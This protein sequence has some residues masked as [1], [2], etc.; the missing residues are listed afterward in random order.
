M[1]EGS[2]IRITDEQRAIR[3]ALRND[4]GR[5]MSARVA[6]AMIDLRATGM[7]VADVCRTTSGVLRDLMEN[8]WVSVEYD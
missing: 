1:A 5:Y 4:L 8:G 2:K 7:G 6:Q 3:N